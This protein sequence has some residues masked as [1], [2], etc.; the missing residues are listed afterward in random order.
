MKTPTKEQVLA[1]RALKKAV[2]RVNSCGLSIVMHDGEVAIHYAEDYESHDF[3]CGA[4]GM[5][6][7]SGEQIDAIDTF[8]GI[9][10]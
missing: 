6:D 5:R 9:H 4:F 1:I 7:E 8:S 10:H 2:K 3:D